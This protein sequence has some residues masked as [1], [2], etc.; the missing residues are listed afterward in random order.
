[1]KLFG[2]CAVLLSLVLGCKPLPVASTDEFCIVKGSPGN[3]YSR[4]EGITIETYCLVWSDTPYMPKECW[5]RVTRRGFVEFDISRVKKNFTQVAIAYKLESTTD[6]RLLAAPVGT[7][8]SKADSWE[9]LSSL[10]LGLGYDGHSGDQTRYYG[11]IEKNT[12]YTL[13]NENAVADLNAALVSGQKWFG[14]GFRHQDDLSN[15]E[16]EATMKD[17]KLVL[18]Y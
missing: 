10:Y 16:L 7:Q 18:I 14:M 5:E 6:V 13:L 1:M 4:D 2:V 12:E 17:V 15:Y 8:P 11:F 3:S 9:A